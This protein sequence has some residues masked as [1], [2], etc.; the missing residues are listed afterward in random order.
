VAVEISRLS[1]EEL[2]QVRPLLLDL[3]EAERVVGSEEPLP[4][5]RLDSWLPQTNAQ[6]AGENHLFAA[7]EEGHLIGFCWCVLFDPGTG[8]EGEVAELYVVP[9]WRGR[10]LGGQ[11]VQEAV[12]LFSSRRV[13]FA[14]VWTRAENGAAVSAYQNA[15][16]APTDQL[17]LTWYP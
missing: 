8:L 16:F 9:S 17:V 15:G 6:F 11:L 14:C 4:R 3:L 5:A 12:R 13:T 10:G 1:E 2:P 7:R